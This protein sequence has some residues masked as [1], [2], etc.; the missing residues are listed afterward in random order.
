[1]FDALKSLLELIP[2]VAIVLSIGIAYGVLKVKS[3]TTASRL[4]QLEAEALSLDSAMRTRVDNIAHDLS[5]HKHDTTDRLARIETK[6]DI[7]LQQNII[8]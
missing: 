6:L 1:M 3:A 5:Q 4:D 8:K 7:L 2:A